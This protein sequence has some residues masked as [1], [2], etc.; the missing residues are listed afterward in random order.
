MRVE[1]DDAGG[2]KS[3]NE[4]EGALD[5]CPEADGRGFTATRH[6]PFLVLEATNV[7]NEEEELHPVA[8]RFSTLSGRSTQNS[9]A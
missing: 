1:V 4:V 6:D 2:L 7:L 8:G 3:F 5:D 9:E